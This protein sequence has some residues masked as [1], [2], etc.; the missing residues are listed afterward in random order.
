MYPSMKTI[1]PPPRQKKE[2]KWGVNIWSYNFSA[3]LKQFLEIGSETFYFF[4]V[5]NV[6]EKTDY[7]FLEQKLPQKRIGTS[8][9]PWYLVAP[10]H[11]IHKASIPPLW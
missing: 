5:S 10:G 9:L 11:I 8:T 4:L 6:S 3:N 2:N 7:G 1:M